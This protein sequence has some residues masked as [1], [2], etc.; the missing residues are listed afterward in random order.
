MR[1]LI[2]VAVVASTHAQQSFI[3]DR[4]STNTRGIVDPNVDGLLN[5]EQQADGLRRALRTVAAA[6]PGARASFAHAR[7]LARAHQALGGL[8]ATASRTSPFVAD[9]AHRAAA[10]F[11]AAAELMPAHAAP[12]YNLGSVYLN[13]FRAHRVAEAERA[14]QRSLSLCPDRPTRRSAGRGPGR[15][16]ALAAGR[17]QQQQ[18][19]ACAQAVALG[20]GH[21]YSRWEKVAGKTGGRRAEAAAYFRLAAE[22]DPKDEIAHFSLAETLRKLKGPALAARLAEAT[23]AYEAAFALDEDLRTVGFRPPGVEAFYSEPDAAGAI[24]AATTTECVADDALLLPAD[25]DADANADADAGPDGV[26]VVPGPGAYRLVDAAAATWRDQWDAA[27][28]ATRLVPKWPPVPARVRARDAALRAAVAAGAVPLKKDP[29]EE[30]VDH[31]LDTA[32]MGV[33]SACA[34][35]AAY[36]ASMRGGGGHAAEPSSV[37]EAAADRAFVLGADDFHVAAWTD[38]VV[39]AVAP[40]AQTCAVLRDVAA[41]RNSSLYRKSFGM[42]GTALF[43]GAPARAARPYRMWLGEWAPMY[44]DSVDGLAWAPPRRAHFKVSRFCI[45]EDTGPRDTPNTT[46]TEEETRPRFLM[47]HGCGV[48][49]GHNLNDGSTCLAH[50]RD[51]DYFAPLHGG[52]HC[53]PACRRASDTYNCAYFDRRAR[54]YRLL[55]R[56]DFGT[57]GGWREIRGVRVSSLPEGAAPQEARAA[58]AWAESASFYLD[59]YDKDERFRYSSSW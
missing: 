9:A 4:T 10:A 33:C 6:A 15:S 18:G 30:P 34:V 54:R 29:K 22:I 48:L 36:R 47:G 11:R 25:A 58:A 37:F 1:L 46:G 44:T 28:N 13:S 59:R 51:G 7:R 56:K 16:A 23:A 31:E 19:S 3:T 55:N 50:S 21:T 8:L 41:R 14:F 24:A 5:D 26:L 12:P 45:T 39:R 38:G 32:H 53:G 49:G 52:A 27:A 20:L 35:D 17:Q 40:P 57:I 43:D 2:L 42:Y